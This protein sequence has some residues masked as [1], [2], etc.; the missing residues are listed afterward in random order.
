MG[1]QKDKRNAWEEGNRRKTEIC[2]GGPGP[3]KWGHPIGESL[4][5]VS[6]VEKTDMES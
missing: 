4:S 6:G 1:S 3:K 5:L 2:L